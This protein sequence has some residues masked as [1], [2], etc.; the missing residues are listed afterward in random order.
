MLRVI[1]LLGLALVNMSQAMTEKEIQQA[2]NQAESR[3]ADVLQMISQ[4]KSE[5]QAEDNASMVRQRLQQSYD[6]YKKVKSFESDYRLKMIEGQVTDVMNKI[7]LNDL[8]TKSEIMNEKKSYGD[9]LYIFISLTMPDEL[10]K[11]YMD[12]ARLI[13]AAPVLRGFKNNSYRETID[14]M[15]DRGIDSGFLIDPTLFRKYNI[16]RVPALVLRS[17]EETL[18][19]DNVSCIPP[20]HVKAT[21]IMSIRS[22][23]E[24]TQ[25]EYKQAEEAAGKWLER[26][27]A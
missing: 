9:G 15:K 21:G 1:V 4:A 17:G 12:T 22:F 5:Y 20:D 13:G 26:L 8:K 16:D 19:Y 18:C 24:R 25:S 10:L 7:D 3:N 27:D 6:E 11:H 23:L 14:A 2:V